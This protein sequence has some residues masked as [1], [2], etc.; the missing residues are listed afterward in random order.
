MCLNKYL[1]NSHKQIRQRFTQRQGQVLSEETSEVHS[2]AHTKGQI[3][4]HMPT[5]WARTIDNFILEK[6]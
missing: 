6:F 1:A 4:S 5:P 3:R 2:S